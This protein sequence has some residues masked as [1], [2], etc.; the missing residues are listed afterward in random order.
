MTRACALIL[1]GCGIAACGLEVACQAVV[2]GQQ[3]ETRKGVLVTID[4]LKSRVP[5]DWVEEDPT[6]RF[7]VKQFRLPAVK[8]DKDNAEVVIFYFGEGSGGSAADNIK[9]WKGMFVPPEGK[10]IDDVTKVEK[11][12]IHGVSATYFDI[13][14][15]YLFKERPFDPA[16]ETSRRPNYRMINVYFESKKGP[17]FFRLVGP[18]DTVENYKKGFDEWVE[19]FQ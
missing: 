10:K 2:Y 8:D 14:G 17:Y 4:G 16:S 19:D 18:A 12:K 13:H 5:T 3:K 11:K 7:R 9:R 15:T 6:S 1:L